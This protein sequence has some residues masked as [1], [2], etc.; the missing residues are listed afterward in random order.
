MTSNIDPAQ[1]E[2]YARLEFRS[3]SDVEKQ[4]MVEDLQAGD[5]DEAVMA[6]IEDLEEGKDPDTVKN[7]L[8]QLMACSGKDY[9]LNPDAWQQW[10]VVEAHAYDDTIDLKLPDSVEPE[11]DLSGMDLDKKA[12]LVGDCGAP[13]EITKNMEITIGRD[14][15]CVCRLETSTVSRL[16][17]VI[18]W[19][20]THFTIRDTDSRNSTKVNGKAIKITTLEHGDLIKIGVFDMRFVYDENFNIEEATTKMLD[21]DTLAIPAIHKG[22]GLAGAIDSLCE[23]MQ[24]LESAKK[25][26]TINILDTTAHENGRIHFQNGLI[27]AA[28]FKNTADEMAVRH[29]LCIEEG[30]FTFEKGEQK[31]KGDCDISPSRIIQYHFHRKKLFEKRTTK[32]LRK[33]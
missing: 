27:I 1:L 17:A 9:G 7:A 15:S 5:Y 28:H 8:I 2:H 21:T 24:F 4:R 31:F 3:L 29:I 13:L 30:G 18:A 32:Q 10:F 26:G 23:I 20:D 11:H 25:S 14:A 22:T 6:L 33:L 19:Q 16:H 12:Y